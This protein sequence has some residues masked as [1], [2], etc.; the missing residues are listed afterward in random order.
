MEVDDAFAGPL[1]ERARASQLSVSSIEGDATR[2]AAAAACRDSSIL[3]SHSGRKM[4]RRTGT[5]FGGLRPLVGLGSSSEKETDFFMRSK[6]EL[7]LSD[8]I[9]A[10]SCRRIASAPPSFLAMAHSGDR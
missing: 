4:D 5:A 6:D 9:D 10:E 7:P 2:S 3:L 8:I 1:P